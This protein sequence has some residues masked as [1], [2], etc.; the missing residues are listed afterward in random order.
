MT[1]PK[2]TDDELINEAMQLADETCDFVKERQSLTDFKEL[3]EFRHRFGERI[4]GLCQAFSERQ[5][6]DRR[7]HLATEAWRTAGGQTNV[8]AALRRLAECL[9][10]RR[11]QL[12]ALLA[13]EPSYRFSLTLQAKQKLESLSAQWPGEDLGAVVSRA[14]VAAEEQARFTKPTDAQR[15]ALD[16]TPRHAEVELQLA[17]EARDV[18][19]RRA[20]EW[21]L[22]LSEVLE[23]AVE[24]AAEQPAT[25]AEAVSHSH[26]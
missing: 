25:L 20:T 21:E 8:P 13:R 6:E 10:G 5:L 7:L 22:S 3:E 9:E 17:P 18:L 14:V 2:L 11:G 4:E 23:Q 15:T 1:A 16:G 19:V 24:A 12:G 26:A